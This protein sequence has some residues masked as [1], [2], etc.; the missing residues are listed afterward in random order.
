MDGSSL[1]TR[2]VKRKVVA[3]SLLA[4]AFVLAS[5]LTAQAAVGVVSNVL[6][7]IQ[8][9]SSD[10]LAEPQAGGFARGE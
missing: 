8:T 10:P 9:S 7:P 4:V 3:S 1:V 6:E 5:A 2:S